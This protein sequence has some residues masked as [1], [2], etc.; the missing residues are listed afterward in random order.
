MTEK[1]EKLVEIIADD[2]GNVTIAVRPVFPSAPEEFSIVSDGQ[3]VALHLENGKSIHL[4]VPED[5]MRAL[6]VADQILIS[7]F[8]DVSGP[9]ERETDIMR[10]NASDFPT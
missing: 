6:Q 1:A 10:K 9:P 7:E 8:K 2:L 4:E 5:E 3:K